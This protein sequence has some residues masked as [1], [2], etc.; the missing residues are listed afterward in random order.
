M[1]DDDIKVYNEQLNAVDKELATCTDDD[2]RA[3]LES[4]RSDIV[5]LLELLKGSENASDSDES[6]SSCETADLP[7]TDCSS[8][9]QSV[10]SYA[11]DLAE[12][13]VGTYCRSPYKKLV[14]RAVRYHTAV[15]LGLQPSD[16]DDIMVSV[17]YMHPMETA[18]K[19]CEYFLDD[20]C[21]Y[22]EACRFSHGEPQLLRDLKD[23]KEPDFSEVNVDSLVLV[24]DES[25][26]WSSA[27]VVAIDG[28]TFA[29][30]LLS[31]GR[32]I[33]TSLDHIVPLETLEADD[34]TQNEQDNSS[35]SSSA[36]NELKSETY[37]NVTVGDIGDWE[38][39]TRGIGMKLML[40]M[41]YRVGEG[42]G[43]NSDGIVHAIQ[44]TLY[45]KNQSLDACLDGK[46]E[47]KTQRMGN[48]RIDLKKAIVKR[49][50]PRN[51]TGDSRDVFDF[52]NSSLS[53]GSSHSSSSALKKDRK[54]IET[55]SS[56]ELGIQSLICDRET[57]Q[58]KRKVHSIRQGLVRNQSDPV[59]V[60]RLRQN[61]KRCEDELAKFS[62]RQKQLTV[63]MEN[64]QNIKKFF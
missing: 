46:N 3:E 45:K 39:H 16:T 18:M 43:R 28:D 49:L 26:L 22:D 30:R 54:Y 35:S 63:Q 33:P 55:C 52:L 8:P 64:R 40:Q 51:S 6:R 44:P 47:K 17:L 34:N 59:T 36:W 37:S 38:R 14:D 11:C 1:S 7:E 13:L 48:K 24:Q 42:L 61:L 25:S 20:R 62:N 15:I 2:R 31:S 4:T 57:K 21:T 41:G 53:A 23:Y 19:P 60:A 50:Q 58:L 29:V 32:E 56:K 12:K 10:D 9:N 5:E 27:R